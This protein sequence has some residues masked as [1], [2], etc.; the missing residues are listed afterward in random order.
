MANIHFLNAESVIKNYGNDKASGVHDITISI[1]PGKITAIVGESGSG[2]STLLKLLYGLLAPDEGEVFFKGELVMGPV[3]KLI[4]GH[5]H[6]KMVTQHTDDLNLFATVRENVSALLPNTN[7]EYKKNE[8]ERMLSQLNVLAL[9]DKRVADLSGGEKQRVA[10]ARALITRPAVLFLDEPFNQVDASFREGLQQNI[11]EIVAQSGL[12]VVMVSHDPA[13]VLSM[14]DE[15]VVLKKGSIVERGTPE[16]M[17]SEPK[18]LYTAQLLS[19]CSI[20]TKQ[21][22]HTCGIDAEKEIVAINPEYIE[23]VDGGLNSNWRINQVLFK[24]FFE[25]LLIEKEG[26]LLRMLNTLRGRYQEGAMVSIRIRKHLEYGS[27]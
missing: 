4:P 2:K 7:L 20:L 5:D 15:L 27:K 21:Q 16:E 12:T 8:T 22:A 9:Q 17:Y 18:M 25:E 26:V 19:R 1:T 23:F 14:A 24:G 3:E 11:R 6:M 10:I 13:E